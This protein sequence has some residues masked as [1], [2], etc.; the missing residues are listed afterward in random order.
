MQAGEEKI[1]DALAADLAK[2][3]AIDT[4]KAVFGVENFFEQLQGKLSE[5]IFD[6]IQKDYNR[7][8]AILYRIDVDEKTVRECLGSNEIFTASDNLAKAVIER[9]L[10]KIRYRMEGY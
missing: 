6:L 10:K 5:Q 7:L 8:L 2:N 9:Q 3:F 4:S 1:Y